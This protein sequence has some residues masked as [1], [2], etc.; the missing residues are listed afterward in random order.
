MSFWDLENLWSSYFLRG[1]FEIMFQGHYIYW[2]PV[3]WS[4]DSWYPDNLSP[5]YWFP[6]TKRLQL[7]PK[8]IRTQTNHPQRTCTL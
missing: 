4:A 7:V 8:T 6:F 2:Y 5:G 3:N 1:I